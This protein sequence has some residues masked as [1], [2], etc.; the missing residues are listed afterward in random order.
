VNNQKKQKS[1]SDQVADQPVL[2]VL[3]LSL[4][5]C[6][7]LAMGIRVYFSPNQMLTWV[8]EA[9]EK[10]GLADSI[11]VEG[12]AL[13]FADGFVPVVFA[14]LTGVSGAWSHSCN[15]RGWW[16]SDRVSLPLNLW[17]LLAGRFGL[18]QVHLHFL[19][20]HIVSSEKKCDERSLTPWV[21]PAKEK[22]QAQLQNSLATEK[23][24][25]TPL[26]GSLLVSMPTSPSVVNQSYIRS[27]LQSIWANWERTDAQLTNAN[28]PA[29][30]VDELRL[31]VEGQSDVSYVFNQVGLDRRLID[32]E[33]TTR[34]RGHV[35][36]ALGERYRPQLEFE[37]LGYE[38]SLRFNFQGRWQEG[39]YSGHW[40]L[41][42]QRNIPLKWSLQFNAEHLA[43]NNIL[44]ILGHQKGF[45]SH[46]QP[47]FAWWSCQGTGIGSVDDSVS[48]FHFNSCG[49]EGEL[50][51]I[52]FD[53]LQLTTESRQGFHSLR[54]FEPYGSKI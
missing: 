8:N 19:E 12:A 27:V 1:Y 37:L 11:E 3:L 17:E 15:D 34:V 52:E 40:Q 6:F 44:K 46:L 36:L 21:A 50:G 43:L 2:S 5:V 7:V 35:S 54:Y 51:K 28:F 39:T 53:G 13:L 16:S 26:I 4:A 33:T 22:N 41:E 38:T 14:Q 24:V 30:Q 23:A 48:S 45:F 18:G 10:E 32:G 31:F 9:L 20:L 25:V 42:K 47:R 49:I 29:I